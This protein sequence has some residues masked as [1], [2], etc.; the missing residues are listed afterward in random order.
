MPRPS[1]LPCLL[2]AMSAAMLAAET[3]PQPLLNLPD[4]V[5]TT[6]QREAGALLIAAIELAVNDSK[7]IY[8]V[9][10]TQDGLDKHLVISQDGALLKV[11]D[12]PAINGALAD[13]QKA[14]VATETAT[15]ETWAAT[16]ESVARALDSFSSTELT[17][18]QVPLAARVALGNAAAG[19]RLT[20]IHATT[21]KQ[22]TIYRAIITRAD[23]T[24]QPIAVHENGSLADVR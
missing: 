7:Q 8:R 18:N 14:L 22:D 6:A 19:D 13:S 5:R 16:K 15:K 12:Y 20:D 11:S 2:I 24:R 9:R 1:L 23:G 21:D 17:L 3:A 4:A 10:L